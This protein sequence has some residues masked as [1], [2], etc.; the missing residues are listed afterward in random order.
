MLPV[1]PIEDHNH[2]TCCDSRR[3]ACETCKGILCQLPSSDKW[4]LQMSQVQAG[5]S[6][7]DSALSTSNTKRYECKDWEISFCEIN[8]TY[9]FKNP[10]KNMRGK[11]ERMGG[12]RMENCI[13]RLHAKSAN[14]QTSHIFRSHNDTVFA[15][16]Q[17]QS[18]NEDSR[19]HA[20]RP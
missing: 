14:E 3:H 18:G 8:S 15:Q 11:T 2:P 17:L 10:H 6:C 12:K 19:C 16:F 9:F 1:D 4:Q 7:T 20:L 13:S 5:L